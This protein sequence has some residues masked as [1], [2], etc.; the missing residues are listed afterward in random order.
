M[1]FHSICVQESH[2]K[3]T[4]TTPHNLPIYATSSFN[5]D[6]V[7]QGMEIFTGQKAGHFYSRFAN[8]TVDAVQ[9]KIAALETFGTDIEASAVMVSSGMAAISTSISSGCMISE[10]N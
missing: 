5:F 1:N 3:L 4:T 10:N 8:P 6:D 7:N 2:G 9:D